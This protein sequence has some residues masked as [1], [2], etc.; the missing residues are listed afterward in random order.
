VL[1]ALREYEEYV[2]EELLASAVRIGESAGETARML[3]VDGNEVAVAAKK[4]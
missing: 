4:A 1:T 3:S 2:S